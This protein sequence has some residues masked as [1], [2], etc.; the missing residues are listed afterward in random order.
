[1]RNEIWKSFR[2]WWVAVPKRWWDMLNVLLTAL[3][4]IAGIVG[5]IWKRNSTE[6]PPLWIILTLAIGGLLFIVMSFWAFHRVRVERD[7]LKEKEEDIKDIASRKEIRQTQLVEITQ[8]PSTLFRMWEL[9]ENILEE[10]KKRKCSKEKVLSIAVELLEI[11]KDDP[12]LNADNYTTEQ[13]FRKISKR[14]REKLRLKKPNPELEARWR[15]RLVDA[16]NEHGVGLMLQQS[17]EY[18]GLETQVKKIS[19][20]ISRTAIYQKMDGFI[21]DLEAL[22]NLRLIMSH[23]KV[24]KNI[25]IFPR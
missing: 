17:H 23:A 5:I 24:K 9:V 1:M 7:Q 22:Y 14:I 4:L 15:R 16:A 20:P 25:S 3:P 18:K 10:K 21:E 13:K 8:I 2:E 19:A 11:P 12:I 6:K